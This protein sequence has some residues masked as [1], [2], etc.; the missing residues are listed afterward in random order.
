MNRIKITIEARQDLNEGHAFYEIQE[1]GAGAYF[2]ACLK[3]DIASLMITAGIHRQLQGYHRVLS[4]I[5][6]YA[7]YYRFSDQV[8]S[9]IALIDTRRA[10]IWIRNRLEQ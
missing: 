4:R 3:T 2:A 5:F 8:V 7:I 10:P 6:P 9:I 1:R